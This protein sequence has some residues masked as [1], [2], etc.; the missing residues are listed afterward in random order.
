MFKKI[1]S[2]LLAIATVITA[3]SLIPAAS[4]EDIGDIAVS[5]AAQ[6]RTYVSAAEAV[7]EESFSILSNNNTEAT[8]LV[9]E[10]AQ[11]ATEAPA[12]ID[13]PVIKS[14]ENL[15]GGAKITWER[16]GNNTSY[17]VYYR[18]AAVYNG[19]WDE[20][21]SSSGWT[22]LATVNGNSYTHKDVKDAEIGIYTVRAVDTNGNFTSNFFS[23]GWENCF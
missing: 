1:I 15:S 4:A 21:Y 22:R 7:G 5:A 11:S 9:T 13:Y 18:K 2:L 6:E 3:F 19:T 20:K 12:V 23:Q 17:R 8:E 14:I 16:Y 10:P